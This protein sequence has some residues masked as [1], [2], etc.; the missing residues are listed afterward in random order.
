MEKTISSS[1]E[2]FPALRRLGQAHHTRRIP[3]IQQ[4][5]ATDCG[6]ACLAMV[7]A[8]YGRH[9]HLDRVRELMGTDR[10]G[11]TALAIIHAGHTY[12]LRG[13]G[14]KLDIDDLAYLEAGTILH[15]EFNHFVVFERLH[16]DSIEIVDPAVGRRQVRLDQVRRSFTG[17]AITFEP[18]ETFQP[19]RAET[20]PLWRSMT[21]LLDQGGRLVQI[22]V[23]S[24]LIQLLALALP[25][26][27]GALVDRVVPRAD[28]QLLLV[29]SVGMLAMVL[30]NSL[31]S[32]LRAHLLLHLRTVLDSRMT[33]GFIDHLVNL[34][35]AF[36]Q[37]RSAGDLMMRLNS[38]ATVRE[39]LT[40]SALSG[41][42]DGVLVSLY[43]VL[44][45]AANATLA[46]LVLGLGVLQIAVFWLS[47]RRYQ[48]LLSQDLQT[49]ARAQSYLVQL[50]AGVETLKASGTEQR[51]VEHWSNLFVDALNVSLARGRL[52]AN[53]GAL[54]GAL[55]LGS[56]LLI[57]LVGGLQVLA[58]QLSL[59]TML[60][61]NALAAAFLGPL[62]SL[63]TNGL[64]L[65][66]VRSY[67]ERI[68]DVLNTPPE[69]DPQHARRADRLRGGIAL[70]EVSF[71][72]GPLA[73][74]VVRDVS[75]DIRP[76]Q[77]VAIVGRSGSGKSTLASL[78]LGLYQPASG[79][80]RYD[81]ANLAELDLGSVRRQLGIVPQ[82]P[83]LFGST[84]R[85]NIALA[86]PTLT[87]D[88]VVRAARLAHIHDDILAMPMGYETIL[89]DGGASLSGGQRQRLALAR[90]LVQQPAILLLDE[91]TS[92]LDTITEG[93]VQ[94]ALAALRCTR[95][96][97]AQRL[98]TIAHA[99]LILVMDAGCL[100]EQGT[101]EELIDRNGVY[102]QLVAAQRA[103]Y[104]SAFGTVS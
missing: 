66:L 7:L 1:T 38:T 81:G 71:Q 46:A 2:R 21:P 56:P 104:G 5:E 49:Q 27:T 35:Y 48:N 61:L 60:A 17:V 58:G 22:G 77:F 41:L 44:L 20:R 37:R 54:Q 39:I 31:A 23:T 34:P 43:L 88:A 62:A 3:F 102:A 97:I 36:F 45:F 51:A 68:D 32:L 72:Y 25:L 78:L 86:D 42:L 64:Q 100:V 16:R 65:Q 103:T 67:I 8:S 80:I 95:I 28:Y 101:H 70:E 69:Q 63:V 11:T 13:R 93:K 55:Q 91:A 57:L 90:A 10:D 89:A 24:I 98:S 30:F 59:G 26:L 14:L 47:R 96:V 52:S 75:V 19:A 79:R 29:L 99:D 84:I 18:S 53:V 92:A 82:H 94:A 6:A 73:P 87:L 83:Y 40:S 33:L 74:A 85:E 50:M 9:E 15:W 4:L 12:G 76:G